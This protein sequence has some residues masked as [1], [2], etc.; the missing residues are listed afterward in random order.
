LQATAEHDPV[1]TAR[2]LAVA[3]LMEP[4]ERLLAPA[5]V[6]RVLRGPLPA[7]RS[8]D[9]AGAARSD[10][11]TSR[12]RVLDGTGA[13]RTGRASNRTRVGVGGGSR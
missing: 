8:G 10:R 11:V 12:G 9:E 13:T 2:F 1:L 3:G 5:I 7:S 6:A 4:P